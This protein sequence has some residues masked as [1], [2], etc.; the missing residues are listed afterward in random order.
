MDGGSL[1]GGRLGRNGG[2]LG[3]L[4]GGRLDSGLR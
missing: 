3:M 4:G 2:K 1:G